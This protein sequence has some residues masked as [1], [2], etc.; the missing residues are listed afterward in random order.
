MQKQRQW[1]STTVLYDGEA[2]EKKTKNRRSL[3]DFSSTKETSELTER[4]N[5]V[6]PWNWRHKAELCQCQLT[7]EGESASP[8]TEAF[9]SS[10]DGGT[11]RPLSATSGLIRILNFFLL[12][13]SLSESL[14]E[15]CFSLEAGERLSRAKC[16]EFDLK[17]LSL[18]V[19]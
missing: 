16:D 8:P 5:T 17:L 2:F 13:S 10:I 1:H 9:S 14:E 3:P 12:S 18:S 15:K 19:C 11:H 6:R 4:M 7:R